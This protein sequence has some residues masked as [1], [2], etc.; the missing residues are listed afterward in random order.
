M[1]AYVECY[2]GAVYPW[3]C[4][5]QGHMTVMFYF[6][7]FDPAS[8]H[9]LSAIGFTRERMAAERRGFVDVKST[10][11]YRSE[12]RA[13]DLI[14]IDAGLLRIGNSS[15]TAHYRMKNPENGELVATLNS[16]TVYFDLDAREPLP[17][18]E[19]V[20]ER[21]QAFLVEKDDG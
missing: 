14:V 7:M 8:W 6:A 10:I 18:P 3:H 17:I 2:R 13:G 4:D 20:R 5:H 1:S 9:L 21:L 15:I 19:A 12:R 11:E 16:V